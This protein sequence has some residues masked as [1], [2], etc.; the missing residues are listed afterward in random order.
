M[1]GA[2]R[3]STILSSLAVHF[4]FLA[5]S[6]CSGNT[7]IE[8]SYCSLL[9]GVNLQL[10]LGHL[11]FCVNECR[12]DFKTFEGNT[13]ILLELK[14]NFG[15]VWPNISGF[16][17]KIRVVLLKDLPQPKKAPGSSAVGGHLW[18][19]KSCRIIAMMIDAMDP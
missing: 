11:N 10:S 18:G 2:V 14:L 6:V 4:D 1:H 3:Y 19:E 16:V 5:S 12:F 9:K 8:S 17:T 13:R 15:R 7:S